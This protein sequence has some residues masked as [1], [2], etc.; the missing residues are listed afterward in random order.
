MCGF[1]R[2][3]IKGTKLLFPLIDYA[4]NKYGGET[5]LQKI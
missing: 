3:G 5:R 4:L 2:N 1:V